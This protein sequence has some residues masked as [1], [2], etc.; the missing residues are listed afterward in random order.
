MKRRTSLFIGFLCALW[1]ITPCFAAAQ[2]T[3]L[4]YMNVTP[5]LAKYAD[6]DIESLRSEADATGMVSQVIVQRED[7]STGEARRFRVTPSADPTVTTPAELAKFPTGSENSESKHLSDFL[8]WGVDAYPAR[9][10][11]VV[12]WG[13]GKG[14]CT[15][16][17]L[18]I[19]AALDALSHHLKRSID[20]VGMDMCCMQ[21]IENL[22]QLASST[23]IVCGSMDIESLAGYD[24]AAILKLLNSGI[25]PRDLAGA[26]P[27]TYAESLKHDEIYPYITESAVASATL[28][29]KLIPALNQLG[30]ELTRYTQD[31]SRWNDIKKLIEANADKIMLGGTRDL[32]LFL[33]D[34]SNE[35]D[36]D[37]TLSAQ[38][39]ATCKALNEAVIQEDLGS[40]Y[41]VPDPTDICK[42]AAVS[43]W[44]PPSNA[45]YHQDFNM[46]R[47]TKLY[48]SHS[49]FHKLGDWATWVNSM[50]PII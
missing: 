19:K 18:K 38:I 29:T 20:V 17:S 39:L 41:P 46:Y 27:L 5:D 26:I 45:D 12:L 1:C 48:H 30:K 13:H 25:S 36:S 8:N 43:V 24:Y 2:W 35:V 37:P 44:L 10:Y 40:D 16:N 23:E 4:I 32:G 9:H 50:Y 28:L 49:L 22:T 15:L 21:T 42:A 7:Q 11:L 14:L 3:L 6:L 31:L 33:E 47:V 34:L